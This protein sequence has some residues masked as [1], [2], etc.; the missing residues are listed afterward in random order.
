LLEVGCS[1]W[2]CGS[3]GG[4]LHPAAVRGA[5]ASGP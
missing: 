2:G 4:K 5:A 1:I 3:Q